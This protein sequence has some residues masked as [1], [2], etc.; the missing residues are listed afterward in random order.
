MNRS[1]V[2]RAILTDTDLLG[3]TID[4]FSNSCVR[5]SLSWSRKMNMAETAVAANSY[6]R[7][8]RLIELY[9]ADA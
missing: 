5:P 1:A 6:M 7:Q 2:A 4:C 3:F 8:Q 9:C